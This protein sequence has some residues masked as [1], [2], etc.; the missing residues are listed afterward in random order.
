MIKKFSLIFWNR[1]KITLLDTILEA[2]FGTLQEFRRANQAGQ[3]DIKNQITA[4]QNNSDTNNPF[5]NFQNN[6]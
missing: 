5:T 3:F 6:H 4:N 2:L 1:I